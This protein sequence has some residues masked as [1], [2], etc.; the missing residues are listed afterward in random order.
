MVRVNI[1]SVDVLKKFEKKIRKR[2][3]GKI[4]PKKNLENKNPE[5]KKFGKGKVWRKKNQEKI[6]SKLINYRR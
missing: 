3:S 4:N 1:D 5:N 2:K 6:C